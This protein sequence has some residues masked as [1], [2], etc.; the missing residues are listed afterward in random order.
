MEDDNKEMEN[1]DNE[2]EEVTIFFLVSTSFIDWRNKVHYGKRMKKLTVI[3]L[4][5]YQ[6]RLL[7]EQDVSM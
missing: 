7:P 3:F 5:N 2:T 1:K 6:G 4:P